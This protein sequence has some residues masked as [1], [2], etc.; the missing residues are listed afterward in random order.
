[1]RLVEFSAFWMILWGVWGCKKEIIVG[2]PHRCDA[3]DVRVA[4]FTLACIEKANPKS[5]EEPEGWIE[6]CKKMGVEIFCPRKKMCRVDVY[7]SP[8]RECSDE[9]L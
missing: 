9:F 1:M 2:S 7:G 3:G 6:L 8:W 4:K 5:D